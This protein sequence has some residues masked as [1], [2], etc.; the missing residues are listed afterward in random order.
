MLRPV[1]SSWYSFG[2]L[3][4]KKGNQSKLVKLVSLAHRAFARFQPMTI[5]TEPSLKTEPIFLLGKAIG[6]S[7]LNVR[8]VSETSRLETRYSRSHRSSRTSNT[9]DRMSLMFTWSSVRLYTMQSMRVEWFLIDQDP[10]VA[11]SFQGVNI[12]M[13][14]DFWCEVLTP[15]PNF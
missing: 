7:A 4:W 9:S 1:K 13:D 3:K 15:A 6:S 11:C 5:N 12:L 10:G 14:P 8:V 2:I